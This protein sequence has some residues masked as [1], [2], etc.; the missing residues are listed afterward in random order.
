MGPKEPCGEDGSWPQSDHPVGADTVQAG[1]TSLYGLGELE[2][3]RNTRT[4]VTLFFATGYGHTSV[5]I[6]AEPLGV[7]P[8][9][10]P[11]ETHLLSHDTESSVCIA[12]L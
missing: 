1:V 6:E 12:E 7:A 5:Q 8:P 11:T 2:K 10:T 3:S 4:D 9:H